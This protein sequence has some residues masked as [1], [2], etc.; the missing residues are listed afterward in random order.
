[1]HLSK[2]HRIGA[3]A[4]RPLAL[5]CI[6]GLLA[7][8]FAGSALGADGGQG[9]L[10][11]ACLAGDSG[12]GG[13][14]F[15]RRFGGSFGSNGS[16][17]AGADSGAPGGSGGGVGGE[18]LVNS[19]VTTTSTGGNGGAGSYTY[20]YLFGSGGGGGGDGIYAVNA[21][22][23]TNQSAIAGGN[24]GVGGLDYRVGGCGGGGGNGVAGSGLTIINFGSI[25]GGAGGNGGRYIGF[26][27]AYYG[28][29][30]GGGGH[31]V[32]GSNLTISNS[33]TITAGAAGA[34]A[35]G[36]YG[37]ADGDA[38]LFTGG[39]NTLNL[40]TGSAITGNIELANSAGVSIYPQNSG[41]IL[42]SNFD[43]D[44]NGASL[45]F[46]TDQAGLTVSGG[47]IG[48]GR[49]AVA[50]AVANPLILSGA[51]SFIGGTFVDG[52]NLQ[53]NGSLG[54]V[55]VEASAS[56]LSGVGNVGN[57]TVT[58]GNVTPGNPGNVFGTLTSSGNGNFSSSGAL[59]I[60]STDG[61]ACSALHVTGGLT[62]AGTLNIHFENTPK[63]G[64]A[65]TIAT[66]SSLSGTF[67]NV[68][69]APATVTV[70]YNSNN[71]TFTVSGNSDSIFADGLEGGAL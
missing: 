52:G 46:H 55:T 40:L 63:I 29:S 19:T 50:G 54:D 70:S 58:T 8:G 31:G 7:L 49:L 17:G 48:G 64:A 27:A 61:S 65:C 68:I 36:A 25:T 23:L 12:N 28:G 69:A 57:I 35:Q 62:L 34:G 43:L 38:I 45:V 1:M 47:I 21:I 41:L 11:A 56:V 32:I 20:D 39:T 4:Q 37:G 59:N 71:I 22:I 13:G 26:G 24:A 42:S 33:G 44:Y 16:G 53:V 9:G 30:G 67:A 51:N 5:A 60:R 2:Q 14:S 66:G 3:G 10:S 15:N 18:L 6:A